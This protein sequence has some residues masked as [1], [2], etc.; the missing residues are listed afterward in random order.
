KALQAGTSHSLGQ[1]FAKAF[2]VKFQDKDKE[3]KYVY[4]TSWGVSTRLIGGM[5]M[6][7][8]DDQGLVIPPKLAPLPVVIVPI[9]RS[10]EEQQK[11]SEFARNITRDWD[12]L[13]YKIDDRD[14]YKP[15]Y[16]FNE[17]ELKGVPLR[18]E[19][20]PRDIQNQQVVLV[21]R[22]TAEKITL[23][24]DNLKEQVQNTLVDIQNNLFKKAKERTEANTFTVDSY[25]EYKER[26]EKGGFFRVFLDH[27]NPEVEQRLKE[28]TKSTIR[29]IPFEAPEEEGPCMITGKPCKYRVIAG[30]AY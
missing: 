7:H 25:D 14:Q 17:W 11:V 29:C 15:G 28:E 6:T 13:F 22:D 27:T 10:D 12:P 5:I 8:S 24:I 4:A 1:N 23:G 21:R 30:Q 9:W 18:I 26:I 2:D 16:K 20:G 3:L 19:I